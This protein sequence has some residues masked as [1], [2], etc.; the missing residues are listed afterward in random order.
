MLGTGISVSREMIAQ[1][2]ADQVKLIQYINC[3]N[4]SWL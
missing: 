4:D 2:T 1:C 3:V